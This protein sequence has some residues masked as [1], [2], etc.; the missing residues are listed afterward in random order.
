[1]SGPV[2]SYISL[3][4]SGELKKRAA[5]LNKILSACTL[6]PRECKVDR[7]KR[8]KRGFCRATNT[9]RIAKAV[10]HFGEEPPVSGTKGSGT[11]FFHFAT[12]G[13]ASA[14]TIR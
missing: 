6:C 8:R 1:M 12:Y 10:P 13:A 11:I 7:K 2:P 14:R 3:Y 9:I 5:R 4:K